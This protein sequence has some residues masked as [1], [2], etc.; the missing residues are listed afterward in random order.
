[1]HPLSPSPR[2]P[3]IRPIFELEEFDFERMRAALD[4]GVVSNNGPMLRQFEAEL[5]SYLEVENVAV[6][7]SGFEALL[8]ALKALRLGPVKAVMPSYTYIA[9]LNSIVQSHM[10]AVLCDID[11][12]TF[13]MDV[14]KLEELLERDP[15]IG[16][17]VPVN[18]FGVPAEMK[19]IE[20]LSEHYGV[21]VVYDNAHGFGTEYLS[22]RT[23]PG[24]AVEVFSLHATKTL[25][26][27]EGGLAVS[28]DKK[29][30]DEIRRLRNH[31][32]SGIREETAPGFNSKMDELRAIVGL[33]SLRIFEEALER[34]RSYALRI[35]GAF[36]RNRD[37]FVTQ[38]VPTGI[39]SNFQN[40]GV[41]CPAAESL[42][43]CRVMEQFAAF[44]IGVRSYFD[45]PIHHIGDFGRGAAF[46]VTQH[47]WQQLISFP[48]HARMSEE[49]LHFL[50]SGIE[51]VSGWIRKN[52]SG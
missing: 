44:G 52:N 47:V 19:A 24:V 28:S 4:S 32:I 14:G 45:P 30:I 42:G 10:H 25:P 11:S 12:A 17:I 5:S 22:S 49:D 29:I 9:T 21:P 1:M 50:C 7:S 40:L 37:V 31:G 27:I 35:R 18:V 36:D 13:T 41:L 2:V 51:E 23:T 8:L 15:D 6:V 3:G 20:R 48:I 43:L 46:P 33:S 39:R 16:C 26:A 34:R 38:F